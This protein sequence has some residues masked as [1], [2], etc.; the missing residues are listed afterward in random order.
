VTSVVTT[1]NPGLTATIDGIDAQGMPIRAIIPMICDGQ[2]HAVP[3]AVPVFDANSCRRPDP[4][5]IEVTST[6]AGMTVLS[7][8]FAV[9]RDGKTI[10]ITDKGVAPNGQQINNV[11]VWDKQ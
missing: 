2:S 9:S 5:T 11:T 6:M 7:G 3:G 1:A 4:Y 10:T 8:T